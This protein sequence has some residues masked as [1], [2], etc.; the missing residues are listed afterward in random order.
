MSMDGH[1]SL[2][3]QI[4]EA[5]AGRN[6]QTVDE[7]QSVV[8]EIARR[9]ND[10]PQSDFF[11]LSPFMMHRI[12]D[13]PYSSPDL[14][15]FPTALVTDP[16]GARAAQLFGLL[17]NEIGNDGVK[18]TANGNLPRA[19]VQ[20]IAAKSVTAEEY[21]AY[22]QE[23]PLRSETG[24][25][26]LHVIRLVGQISGLIRKANG[27]FLLTKICQKHL[28]QS[29]LKEV[30]PRLLKAYAMKF[31]WSY[32][33][34]D[35][36]IPLIQQAFAFTLYLLDRYGDDWRPPSFYEDAFLKAFP[37]V[38]SQITGS[39]YTSPEKSFRNRYTS[40]CLSHFCR[41]FGLIEPEYQ[42]VDRIQ[43][44]SALRKSSLFSETARFH[45]AG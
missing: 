7:A 25:H 30:Y 40:R 1:D 29:G 9:R 41:A 44:I 18:T 15:E 36:D 38:L 28:A 2:I 3:P 34:W 12:L 26:E 42:E 23:F 19:L 6:F 24:F 21:A 31:N 4:K 22:T 8:Q 16:D 17:A 5:M 13:F 32:G 37:Q 35:L 45:M 27:R 10:A 14:I 43:Q 33:G 20:A 11:G 39:L